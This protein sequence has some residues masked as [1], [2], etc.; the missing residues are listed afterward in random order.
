MNHKKLLVLLGAMCGSTQILAIVLPVTQPIGT[1]VRNWNPGD[2]RPFPIQ[3][4]AQPNYPVGYNPADAIKEV[5]YICAQWDLEEIP[6]TAPFDINYPASEIILTQPQHFV[7]LL[8]A[9]NS[10]PNGSW[11]MRSEYVRGRTPAELK[12]IFALAND[13]IDIVDVEMPGSPNLISGKEYALWTGVAGPIRFLPNYNWGDGGAPQNRL[14]VDFN[15]TN[16]FPA[17]YGYT[18]ASTR[19]HRRPVGAIALAYSP[20]AGNGNPGQV[21]T[22]LDDPFIPTAYSDLENV[23]HALDW[24]NYPNFGPVPLQNALQQIS[25]E[26]YSAL[27]CT[28][29]RNSVLFSTALL[30]ANPYRRHQRQTEC[31]EADG[32]FSCD[33]KINVWAQGLGEWDANTRSDIYNAFSAHSGGIMACIDVAER[34][35]FVWGIG[36]TGLFN[37]LEW[38]DETG[39]ARGGNFK[40]GLYG[41]YC[42]SSF[43]VD[44]V[45]CAGGHWNTVA[46][47]I[48]FTGVNRT[49][50][51]KPKG[52]D[53]DLS[54]QIGKTLKGCVTPLVRLA[55]LFNRHNQ[56]CETG[57]DSLNLRVCGFNRHTFRA[58]LGLE[59][60]PVL[61]TANGAKIIPH[62]SLAWVGEYAFHKRPIRAQLIN[63]PTDYMCINSTC[64]TGSTCQLGVGCNF[65]FPCN[66]ALSLRYDAQLRS[67]LTAQSMHIG[68]ATTF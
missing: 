47:G 34:P 12:D 5:N 3:P 61:D 31:Q 37:H 51:S 60:D 15:G 42:R 29:L 63:G 20:M 59:I 8:V 50:C 32:C 46:R 28:S 24:L 39:N 6:E 19:F 36:A 11:I 18:S 35:N 54:L 66:V 9:S 30:D 1:L 23:Y 45:L 64:C 68:L 56:F 7:R 2:P 38:C 62:A 58:H 55:Y 44:G 21:A 17:T 14:I 52:G 57:A 16:Y 67:G 33:P 53:F 4:P 65:I 27:A 26:R 13:P 40:V 41:S 22:Y 25:P 49:A 48:K 10:S 43:F